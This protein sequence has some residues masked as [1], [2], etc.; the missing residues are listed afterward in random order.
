[1]TNYTYIT[2]NDPSAP[3]YTA[4]AGINA[5]GEIVGYYI[6]GSGNEYGFLYNGTW[7]KLDD[8]S[9]GG[10]VNG[11]QAFGV[12]ASGEIVGVYED[13]SNVY[14]GFLYNNGTFTTLNDGA[15]GTFAYGI[16]AA[17][18]VVGFYY[19]SGGV[20]HGFLYNGST[21]TTLNDSLAGSGVGQGTIATGINDSGQIV[22]YYLDSSG[23]EN[24]FLYSGGTYTT[25]DDSLG[26]DGT[27]AL[28]INNSGQIV[29][30]YVDGSG[31]KH[32]FLYSGGTY[33]TIDDSSGTDGTVAFGINNAGQISG[34]YIASNGT[35]A[36]IASLPPTFT[37]VSENPSTGD[38]NAGNTV[39]I[40]LS[41]NEA[42]TV[43]GTPTLTLND[44]GTAN[45]EAA[46]STSTS[47]VFDYTVA[48][49][50]M[51][52][53]SLAVTQV[54]LNGA[55][56]QDVVGNN[57]SLS[58]SGL[59]QSGPQID[60]TMPAAAVPN[61]FNGDG[62]S[63]MLW[64]NSNGTLAM[65]LMDGSA[66]ASSATPT[67]Q[68][69]AV[70]PGASW[71]V[72]GIGD[73]NGDGDADILWRNSNGSLAEW[74]MDGSTIS[75]S[76]TPT[77]QGSAVSPGASWSVAG[78]GDFTGD[79]DADILWQNTNGSLAMWLMDGSTITSSATP[80]YEGSAVSPGA[81]WSV[82]GIGDFTGNGD[83]DI[84]WRNTNG[85]LTMWLMGG[86]TIESS[87]T[88]TYE[89][90]AVSPGSSWSVAGIGDFTGNGDADILWR[91]SNGSLAMWLMDGST[92]ELSATPTYQGSAVS[93][94]SSWNIV[95]IG[96]FKGPGDS[97]ILWQQSTTGALV[98]WQMNG[99][100][101]VSSQ[102]VTSQGAPV[103]P[104]STWTPQAKPTDFAA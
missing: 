16:N 57:A 58:L 64:R 97:D 15:D 103:A 27:V 35:N 47:L 41:T 99:S 17:G 63:D 102:S 54:N 4:G 104:G 5:S 11:T 85:S 31:V 24:G 9:E 2:L 80:T 79:G 59:T 83:D 55:T 76:A 68:G 86:S 84:L 38:L 37:A 92:I 74:L 71:S 10:G 45:Y 18:E 30:Y 49:S 33:T 36:F 6:D 26:T 46:A 44:N 95:E 8:S 52:V 53:A 61:D 69:S 94:D 40:T 23:A 32:G 88:P 12:N 42:V 34:Y 75:S 82:A 96:D 7:T 101:I 48:A 19:D 77:Y 93:P 50:D 72:A 90:S 67:Y 81:S 13:S 3:S 1:M 28:G 22:G 65:W 51:D 56:I 43:S 14:H 20:S 89:G 91:N 70:S 98:E 66:I 21:F 39:T 25:I 87:A 62:M 60:I 73:F 100:Q 78:I 29:G